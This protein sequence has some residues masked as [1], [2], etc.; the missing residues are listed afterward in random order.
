V[1][2]HVSAVFN[3]LSTLSKI[4]ELFEKEFPDK[5]I[6]HKENHTTMTIY[7]QRAK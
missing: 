1:E 7:N 4:I 2:I 3:T 5:V 6:L